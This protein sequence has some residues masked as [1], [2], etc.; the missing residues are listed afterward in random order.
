MR[1][2]VANDR[3][4]F[5]VYLF[6]LKFEDD[7]GFDTPI[8][9]GD[10]R[11]ARFIPTVGSAPRSLSR[12]LHRCGDLLYVLVNSSR[13]HPGVRSPKVHL[14]VLTGPAVIN[15][16]RRAIEIEKAAPV[17][18]RTASGIKLYRSGLPRRPEFEAAD[19]KSC[20]W[21]EQA[22]ADIVQRPRHVGFTPESRHSQCE[23]DVGQVQ[24]S[25]IAAPSSQLAAAKS[26]ILTGMELA[27]QMPWRLMTRSWP[28]SINI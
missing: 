9:E 19:P 20:Y 18:A 22:L 11:G 12:A 1:K 25:D 24:I 2:T 8:T 10:S 26:A 14:G 3:I 21:R 5:M 7:A 4:R 28:Q 15:L 16:H 27:I 23:W 6:S 17:S 13:R